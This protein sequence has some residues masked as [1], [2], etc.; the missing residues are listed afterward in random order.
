MIKPEDFIKPKEDD[1]KIGIQVS[2]NFICQ[3]CLVSV[4]EAVLD[5]EKMVLVYIC[6]DGHVNEATL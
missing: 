4:Y 5:E 2:G 3:E 1:Q 6:S